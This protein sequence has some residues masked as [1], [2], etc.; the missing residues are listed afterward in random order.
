M[1]LKAFVRE[2]SDQS[3]DKM[4]RLILESR[5]NFVER[6][7]ALKLFGRFC[8]AI[9]TYSEGQTYADVLQLFFSQVCKTTIQSHRKIINTNI[10]EDQWKCFSY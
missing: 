1:Q 5:I 8:R 2:R 6:K 7:I 9:K 3:F 4:E 10:D